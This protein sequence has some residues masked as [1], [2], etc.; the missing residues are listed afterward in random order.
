MWEYEVTDYLSTVSMPGIMVLV[1]DL[2]QQGI[3]MVQNM[4]YR[5]EVVG[6]PC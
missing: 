5:F 4:A 6:Y 2:D 1:E 3:N